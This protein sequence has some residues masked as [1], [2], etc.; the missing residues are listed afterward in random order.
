MPLDGFKSRGNGPGKSAF[1]PV[2]GKRTLHMGEGF[3]VIAP[4]KSQTF[5]LDLLMLFLTSF[6]KHICDNVR[7]RHLHGL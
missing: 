3:F 7:D 4:R 2:A 6:P 1:V 5:E